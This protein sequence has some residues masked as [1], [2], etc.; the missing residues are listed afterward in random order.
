MN[1]Q[2]LVI[3]LIMALGLRQKV[4]NGRMMGKSYPVEPVPTPFSRALTEL[5]GAAGG[6]YLSVMLLIEFLS[7]DI[8]SRVSIIGLEMDPLALGAILIA[9]VQPFFVKVQLARKR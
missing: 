1:Y 7:V 9:S 6:I 8:P 4:L 3:F 5:L 2:V